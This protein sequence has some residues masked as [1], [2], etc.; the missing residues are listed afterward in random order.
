MYKGKLMESLMLQGLF[1]AIEFALFSP[2]FKASD[3][4]FRLF[5]QLFSI[6][7]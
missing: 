2:V 6:L 1:E 4:V 3:I 7:Q 5:D